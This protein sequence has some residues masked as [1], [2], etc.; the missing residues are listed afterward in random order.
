MPFAYWYLEQS[1]ED[2]LSSTALSKAYCYE[3]KSPDGPFIGGLA[4]LVA[5]IVVLLVM[6]G[7]P[8]YPQNAPMNT[9]A[10]IVE[11]QL[12]D[13]FKNCSD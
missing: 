4:M 2:V 1:L 12:Q 13:S 3:Y 9:P 10:T 11:S 6:S 7:V 5:L 8:G